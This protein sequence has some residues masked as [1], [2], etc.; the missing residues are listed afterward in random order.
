MRILICSEA[1]LANIFVFLP[2]IPC[3]TEGSLQLALSGGRTSLS[4]DFSGL[5][6]YRRLHVPLFNQKNPTFA[7]EKR[8]PKC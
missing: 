3:L 1:A 4:P 5:L 7:P 8:N 6:I 2:L